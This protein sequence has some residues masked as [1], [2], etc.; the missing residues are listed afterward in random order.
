MAKQS[1]SSSNGSL[2]PGFTNSTDGRYFFRVASHGQH[3]TGKNHWAFT[4]PGPIGCMPLDQNFFYTAEKC[5]KEMR[6]EIIWPKDAKEKLMRNPAYLVGKSKEEIRKIYQ[7]K[8]KWFDDQY[9]T[10][11]ENRDVRTIVI[12]TGTQLWDSILF[13]HFGRTDRDTDDPQARNINNLGR[14][15]ANADITDYVTA[16]EDKHLIVIHKSK[17]LWR[18][19]A[20][21]NGKMEMAGYSGVTYLV[22]AVIEHAKDEETHEDRC[23]KR[24]ECQCF[25]VRIEDSQANP[26]LNGE[27]LKG[28]E[29]DFES[30]AMKVFPES[31]E[32]DWR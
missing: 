1:S 26:M 18:G 21:V 10:L 9:Y 32:R 5:A 14:G 22:N 23:K 31:D 19:G 20:P 13:R 29:C 28:Y 12:D 17:Q 27:V 25:E 6:K 2:I 16:V 24:G 7:E 3:R 4:A 15:P 8:M 30:L 11:T